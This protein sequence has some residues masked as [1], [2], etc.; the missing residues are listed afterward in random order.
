MERITIYHGSDHIIKEPIFGFGN[1]HNDY[2]LA[3]YCTSELDKAKEWANRNTTSG[4]VNKYMFDGRGLSILD[5]TDS[6]YSVLNW[7]AILMHFRELSTAQRALYKRR[8]EFLEEHYYIDVSQYDAVIGY[9]ADDAYFKFPLFFIQ[10][11]LSVERLEEIYHLGNLGKQIA[12]VS[13]KAFKR[14]TYLSFLEVEAKYNNLYQVNKNAADLRFETIRVEEL[15]SN[16]K[17]IEDLMKDY[18]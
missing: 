9:R 2:G 15:N 14:L 6:K 1:E 11:E 17:K 5:L 3:F 18:D 4:Y 10:N 7:I 13:E 8:L 12:V 16:K